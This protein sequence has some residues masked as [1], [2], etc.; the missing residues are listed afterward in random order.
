MVDK[1]PAER[2]KFVTSIINTLEVYNGMYKI[3]TKKS[4]L[5]KSMIN[6]ILAKINTI[7][8]PN[9]LSGTLANVNARIEDL[10][11]Q[12]VVYQ[13]KIADARS[14]IKLLDPTGDI[15]NQYDIIYTDMK[16]Y[17]NEINL[18]TNQIDRLGLDIP[19]DEIEEV[20]N[21]TLKNITKLE[22]LISTAQNTISSL[23]QEQDEKYKS[24]NAK[25]EK[26][27]SISSDKNKQ[28]YED[29]IA[30]YKN[31]IANQEYI[32]SNM[33]LLG[34]NVTKDEFVTGLNIL[35]DIR[36]SIISLQDKFPYDIIQEAIINYIPSGTYPD[37]PAIQDQID[38]L[39]MIIN[40]DSMLLRGYLDQERLSFKLNERPMNCNIDSCPFI[41]DAVEAVNSG[42][43]NKI[44]DIQTAIDN[45]TEILNALKVEIEKARY[46]T[47]AINLTQS[48]LKRLV[49]YKSILSKLPNGLEY[50]DRNHIL[51]RILSNDSFQDINKL[52]S[53][54]DS[55]NILEE[56]K[57]NKEA[58][59]K[60]MTEY[61]IYLSKEDIVNE[62]QSDI[63]S[64][65]RS[66]KSIEER[67]LNMRS[68]L[69]KS[70]R[71]LSDARL[72]ESRLSLSD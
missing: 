20:Y 39:T 54:I 49:S 18:L 47:E 38:N 1:K 23:L 24:M 56:Y 4:S 36:T 63:D 62:I 8:D 59:D 31:N 40:E 17:D 7:G 34:S 11:K 9:A 35:E 53:Q 48:F 43:I 5:Y 13:D 51:K 69:E 71:E 42:N 66:L 32:L 3:L 27:R 46:T 45:N 22:T 12:I 2:K 58:L 64:I 57:I 61:N 25:I 16:R 19:K 37:V 15:R 14:T 67:I 60:L 41:K 28:Y 55:A 44:V 6:S 68:G 72:L 33:G 52:Y 29:T 10:N 65:D 50:I 26:L 70:N 21:K 30:E